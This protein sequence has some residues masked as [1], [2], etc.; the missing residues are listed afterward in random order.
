MFGNDEIQSVE[1]AAL[2]DN[3]VPIEGKITTLPMRTIC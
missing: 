3:L 2:D 1:A